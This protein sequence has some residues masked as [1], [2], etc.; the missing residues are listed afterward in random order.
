M[1]VPASLQRMVDA[2]RT[3]ESIGQRARILPDGC[4]DFVF[5]LDTATARLTGSTTRA[6]LVQHAPG[7]RPDRTLPTNSM[8]ALIERTTFYGA[9]ES[10]LELPGGTIL[11]L[12]G[13]AERRPIPR[14]ALKTC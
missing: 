8:T 3:F 4:M 10:W 12:S 2:F 13:M 7:R 11:G 5:D 9:T 14:G 6:E 1:T